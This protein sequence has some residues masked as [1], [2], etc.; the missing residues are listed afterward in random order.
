M[1][2][3]Y[4]SNTTVKKLFGLYSQFEFQLPLP[5]SGHKKKPHP[6]SW[7]GFFRVSA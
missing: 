6:I 5:V 2:Q 7:V 1:R 4:N 3:Q